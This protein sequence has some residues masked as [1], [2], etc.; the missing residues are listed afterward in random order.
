MKNIT[1]SVDDDIYRRARGRAARE[2]TS[3]SQVVKATLLR[4]VTEESEDER[5]ARELTALFSDI[6]ASLT[7]QPAQIIERGWRDQMYDERFD[8]SVLGRALAK[9]GK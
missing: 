1:V 6:D 4:F 8:T 7:A 3:V 2:G 5:R 9:Q